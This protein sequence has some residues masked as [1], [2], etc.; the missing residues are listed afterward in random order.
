LVG[1]EYDF[2]LFDTP[3]IAVV[4]DAIILSKV[5]SGV[6]L[7]VENGKTSRKVLPRINQKLKD[8]KARVLGVVLNK[9]ATA[10]RD[11]QYYSYYYG[12]TR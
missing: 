5:V 2:I 4:T 8:A 9:V 10:G 3:P 1:K 12:R 7:V 11:Y 6:I